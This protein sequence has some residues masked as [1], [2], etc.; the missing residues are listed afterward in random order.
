MIIQGRLHTNFQLE[1]L[2]KRRCSLC[3]YLF[4]Q[5][6]EYRQKNRFWRL[7]LGFEY[8]KIWT[9]QA[10]SNSDLEFRKNEAKSKTSGSLWHRFLLSQPTSMYQVALLKKIFISAPGLCQSSNTP[11]LTFLSH[12]FYT[13]ISLHSGPITLLAIA[14]IKTFTPL[15]LGTWDFLC[16]ESLSCLKGLDESLQNSTLKITS[17]KPSTTLPF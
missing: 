15:D 2:S 6:R 12:S 17:E 8:E 14:Q 9:W 3:I 5:G 10:A 11:Q 1:E 7:N 4:F 13:F 16:L